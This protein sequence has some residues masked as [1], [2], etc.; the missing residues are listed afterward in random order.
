ME[1]IDNCI[2][3]ELQDKIENY[4][5]Q[6]TF[7]WFYQAHSLQ[8]DQ[9]KKYKIETKDTFN[10]PQFT[11]KFVDD[12]KI[13][14]SHID[15]VIELLKELKMETSKVLRCKANL[16]FRTS[17]KKLHNIF[18]VDSPSPHK[19]LIYYIKDSDGD[20]HI[21]LDKSIKKINPKKGR[22]L[23]FD[24]SLMHAANHPKI[25]STRLVLNFNL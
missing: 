4:F 3:K 1:I 19:V 25:N 7:P 6:N 14:S 24:G 12:G 10:E 11:H 13:N 21:K 16:K 8:K 23:T 20:T 5:L 17:S 9:P 22:V 2:S 15:I 18:H